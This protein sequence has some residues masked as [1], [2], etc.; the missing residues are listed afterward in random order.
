MKLFAGGLWARFLS[1]LLICS[2]VSVSFGSAANARFISPDTMD[3]TLPGVGTNRYSYSENDPINK[4]DPNGHSV[5]PDVSDYGSEGTGGDKGNQQAETQSSKDISDSAGIARED[6][7]QDKKS[8]NQ[9]AGGKTDENHNGIEDSAEPTAPHAISLS[10]R[11]EETI[12]GIKVREMM[13][14]PASMMA[15]NFVVTPQGVALPVPKD[16]NPIPGPVTNRAGNVTGSAFTG[17]GPTGKSMSLRMMDAREPMA[18]RGARTSDIQGYS[19]GY[20]TYSSPT[21][22]GGTQAV[23]PYDGR[24]ISKDHPFSHISN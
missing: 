2:M 24:T 12:S 20:N 11:P 4:S 13:A 9:I 16:A 18:P 10:P 23:N 1:L 14:P 3:P 5:S 19:N 17:T 8:Q 22:N 7:M 21:P 6:G 15:P